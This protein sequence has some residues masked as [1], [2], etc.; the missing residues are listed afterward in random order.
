MSAQRWLSIL[1]SAL[2]VLTLAGLTFVPSTLIP[3]A[4]WA[5]FFGGYNLVVCIVHTVRAKSLQKADMGRLLAGA[6]FTATAAAIAMGV[7]RPIPLIS[8]V[9]GTVLL[10]G[11]LWSAFNAGT[12]QANEPRDD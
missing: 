8:I 11:L 1:D 4:A 3:V 12:D 6:V 5:A 9:I 2:F 7:T 10:T